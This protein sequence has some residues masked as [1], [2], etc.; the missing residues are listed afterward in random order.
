MPAAMLSLGISSCLKQS[1]TPNLDPSGSNN[2]VEFQNTIRPESYTTPLPAYDNN[3]LVVTNDTTGFNILVDYA[4]SAAVTPQDI[5]VTIAVDTTLLATYNTAEGTSYKIP[6]ASTFSFPATIT[7]PRGQSTGTGHVSIKNASLLSFTAAYGLPLTL[8][9]S[10]YGIL[11]SNY[12]NA[13]F[14]FTLAN[15]WAGTYAATG[16]F[17]H[18][19]SPR[20][21]SGDWAVSTAGA[22]TC[23]FPFG[24]LGT[25]SSNYFFKADVP[26]AGGALTN[27]QA[28]G[29][30]PSGGGSG[31]MTADDPGGI[32]ASSSASVKPGQ[33]P[34]QSATYNNT[35]DASKK[36]FWLHVGY[37]GGGSG[38]NTWSRQV[39]QKMVKE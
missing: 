25:S 14:E 37:A 7:I 33:S 6:D 20:T 30:T 31:F 28:V 9:S 5:Q 8:K 35:Y 32:Y 26:V 24:D 11:S 16:Y 1:V 36:T 34:W 27:Y 17:F 12:N 21:L 19:S 23:K 29:S 18:P 4:G 3:D 39:Y 15:P 22:V 38:Q 10:S 13:I 2:V